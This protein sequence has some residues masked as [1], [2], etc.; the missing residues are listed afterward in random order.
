M[1]FSNG[2]LEGD[3][4]TAWFLYCL[5]LWLVFFPLYIMSRNRL[6]SRVVVHRR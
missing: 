5:F 6:V 2:F 4:P 3:T 1:I